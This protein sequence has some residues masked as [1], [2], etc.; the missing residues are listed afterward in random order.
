[1]L[2]LDEKL[3]DSVLNCMVTGIYPNAQYITVNQIVSELAKLEPIEKKKKPT[4]E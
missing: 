1:M 3:R 2:Q 4:K